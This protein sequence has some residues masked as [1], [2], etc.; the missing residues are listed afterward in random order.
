MIGTVISLFFICGCGNNPDPA[1]NAEMESPEQTNLPQVEEKLISEKEDSEIE[2][3]RLSDVLG[4]EPVEA[5]RYLYRGWPL[6]EGEPSEV[7]TKTMLR[8]EEGDSEAQFL[9]S[10]M[11]L[12]GRGT[13]FDPVICA[14]WSS[15]AAKNEF[16]EGK[17]LL[18]WLYFEGIGVD[19]D[20]DK[21]ALLW[22]EVTRE[23]QSILESVTEDDTEL[24]LRF[25]VEA[26]WVLGQ[27]IKIK[28]YPDLT[29]TAAI[30]EYSST[31]F[32]EPL[33]QNSLGEFYEKGLGVE[34]NYSKAVEL[35]SSAAQQGLLAAY[36]NM[37]NL[38]LIGLGVPKS[39]EMAKSFYLDAAKA[40]YPKGQLK[41]GLWYSG[42][43]TEEYNAS[44]ALSWLDKA[45]NNNMPEAWFKLGFLYMGLGP[46]LFRDDDGV[47]KD[48]DK[49][50]RYLERAVDAGF[51]DAYAYLSGI[52]FMG[53]GGRKDVPR[54]ISLC[55]ESIKLGNDFGC[56]TLGK[57]FEE[58]EVVD[59]NMGLAVKYY[60]RGVEL[61]EP[62]CL[63]R[64]ALMHKEGEIVEHNYD[65][66]EKLLR[67]AADQDNGKA[68]FELGLLYYN[69]PEKYRNKEEAA[70]L[71]QKAAKLHSGFALFHLGQMY[72]DGDVFA[73]DYGKAMELYRQAAFRG[74]FRAQMKLVLYFTEKGIEATEADVIEG[75]AWVNICLVADPGIKEFVRLRDSI[76][77]IISSDALNKAQNKA[78][79]YLS[80]IR[81]NPLNRLGF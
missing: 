35:Y 27:I 73:K 14:D 81:D 24:K 8:A 34:Q 25:R 53:L 70:E 52:F 7:F 50:I 59:K 2:P 12:F 22:G 62:Y 67:L 37:G 47:P 33:S 36:V 78:L 71:F 80:R 64:V 48:I 43:Y 31:M 11:Y 13:A 3:E 76:E 60:K 69:G 44:E 55:E 74:M 57:Y 23:F 68:L 40:G 39:Y 20:I 32:N 4:V 58:G 61:G 9:V 30:Y 72:E 17:D 41:M 45:S 38:Y 16:T 6:P 15:K 10:L 77:K 18:A 49:A 26:F 29:F 5:I 66:T 65:L 75:Y 63:V 19:L 56:F 79:E 21:A 54:A 51:P 46:G 28:E 1:E 42:E